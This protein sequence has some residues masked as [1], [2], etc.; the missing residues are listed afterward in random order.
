MFPWEAILFCSG[1]ESLCTDGVVIASW[2]NQSVHPVITHPGY[3][4]TDDKESA[5]I[6]RGQQF[7]L[8]LNV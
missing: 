6:W 5:A 1:F 2:D 3:C 8:I 4:C 7:H